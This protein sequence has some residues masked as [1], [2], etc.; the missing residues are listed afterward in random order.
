M[1]YLGETTFVMQ[2]SSC[3][4]IE[5]LRLRLSQRLQRHCIDD[6]RGCCDAYCRLGQK[7]DRNRLKL[8]FLSVV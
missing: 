4:Y 5:L 6:L 7:S 8:C 2:L 1:H 3:R